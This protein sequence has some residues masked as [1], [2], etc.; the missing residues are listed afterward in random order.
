MKEYKRL[1]TKGKITKENTILIKNEHNDIL[2][3]QDA[4]DML[5]N[6][7]NRLTEL[8]DK[9]EN[10]TLIELPCKVGDT[11]YWITSNNRD[12][13]EVLVKRIAFAEL[14]RTILYVEEKGLGEYTIMFVDDIYKTKAEAETKLKELQKNENT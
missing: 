9:I 14:D 8:E 6:A 11:I 4:Y 1:T 5:V 2:M 7:F 12:I 3:H 13:I 10:G